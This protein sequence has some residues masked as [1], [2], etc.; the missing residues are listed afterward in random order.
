MIYLTDTLPNACPGCGKSHAKA[1][2]DANIGDFEA[3]ASLQCD[4]GAMCQYVPTPQI[5]EAAKLNPHGD[6]H[7]YANR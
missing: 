6:L 3:G 5:I 4:C 1:W 2:K 7:R